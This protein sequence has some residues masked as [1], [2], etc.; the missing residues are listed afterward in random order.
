[1]RGCETAEEA[2]TGAA[3][4]LSLVTADQSI[5][6]AQSV[7]SAIE[8]GALFCD[9]NSVA[10]ATKRAASHSIDQ[11]GARYADVA[12][13]S[14]V[15]PA[16]AGAPLLVSG[17]HASDAASALREAGFSSVAI[18]DGP[19][20]A[21]SAVKL[22]RSIM[23]K[24]IEALCAECFL[25]AQASGAT[26]AVIASLDA[27]G[28]G[29]DW[30]RRADYNLDRMMVHGRRRAAE[31]EEALNMLGDLG[32]DGPMTEATIAWH[33]KIGSMASAPPH[34][35]LAK[36]SVLLGAKARAA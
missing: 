24:G 32:L 3:L 18:I 9:M 33:R 5:V 36:T 12:V 28:P 26:E 4:I 27:S 11:A 23:V 1:V 14:P 34:G 29:A 7:A 15:R 10:P 8:P 20:G 2:V 25:A 13:M 31:M 6:A 35:L 16:G 17:P 22:V 30:A 21:A 19:L